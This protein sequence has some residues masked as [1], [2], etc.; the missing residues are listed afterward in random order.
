MRSPS[1]EAR[2]AKALQAGAIGLVEG[3]LEHI[4]EPVRGSDCRD[5]VGHPVDVLFALDDAGSG[6]QNQPRRVA[7]IRSEF[8]AHAVYSGSGS[9]G[10]SRDARRCAR[11]LH[12]AAMNALNSG[13]GSSGFD[14]NSGWNW[15]PR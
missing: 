13:C 15:Q 6:D 2:S 14:L 12:A 9:S 7:E 10:A 8:N 11:Y 3:R 1:V 5:R 4:R